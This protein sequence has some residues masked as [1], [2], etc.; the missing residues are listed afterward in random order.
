MMA[1]LQPI[2]P[3]FFVNAPILMTETFEV[4]RPADDVWAELVVEHP[5]EFLGI[6]KRI[7]WT[8]PRPFGVGTT[9]TAHAYL[10][11]LVLNERFIVWD[12]G[13]RMAFGVESSNLPVFRRFG[14]DYRIE[15]TSPESCT[16]TWTIASDPQPYLKPFKR[17]VIRVS[18]WSMFGDARIH[19]EST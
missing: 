9:R 12:E 6:I 5:M 2:G 8:S 1:K 17:P 13:R 14:E 15:P 7:D 19:F 10:G 4:P 16:L 3:T 18:E 11:A